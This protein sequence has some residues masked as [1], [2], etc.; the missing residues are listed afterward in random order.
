MQRTDALRDTLEAL[1]KV[2]N[3]HDNVPVEF[4]KPSRAVPEGGQTPDGY[5]AEDTVVVSPNV[6]DE[7]GR[8]LSGPQELRCIANTL[9]HEIEHIRESD[10]TSKE[11]FSQEYDRGQLAGG[12]INI[13]EDVYID[14]HRTK[15]FPGLRKAQAFVVDALMQNHH[16]R[17]RVDRIDQRPKQILETTLQVAFAGSAK[18]ISEADDDL[19]EYAGRVRVLIDEARRAGDQQQR[20]NIA[21][22]VMDVADEYLPETA[23][24][25]M[26]DECAVCE[27][28]EPVIIVPMLGPVCEQCA[29]S[30]HGGDDSGQGDGSRPDDPA[31]ETGSETVEKVVEMPDDVDGDDAD[32]GDAADGGEDGEAGDGDGDGAGEAGDDAGGEGGEA[33][34]GD[35]GGDGGDSGRGGDDG[36]GSDDDAGRSID[37]RDW[38]W[39]DLGDHEDHT[40]SVVDDDAEV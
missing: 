39:L 16:R 17:P 36:R 22:A 8:D 29:P 34:D 20:K 4:G 38:D 9:S 35:G 7:L 32:G 30:G 6:R 23:D 11:E 26:P 19:R 37:P 15:R 31:G 13:V 25:E 40:V 14:N 3:E 10:L 28:R 5:A 18:G 21:H 12:V 24:Y 1:A 33:G 27:Q 2:Y